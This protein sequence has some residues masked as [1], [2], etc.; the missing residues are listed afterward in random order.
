MTRGS[1]T[2]K[3]ETTT[4]TEDHQMPDPAGADTPDAARDRETDAARN[5]EADAIRD[6]ETGTARDQET[7]TTRSREAD[8]ARGR[9]TDAAQDRAADAARAPEGARELLPVATPARTRAVIRQLLRPHRGL[10]FGGF[11]VMVGATTVGLL[12]Q[13]L[14]GYLVDLVTE[15]RRST[16]S[17]CR[18]CSWCSS[19]SRRESPPR[20]GCR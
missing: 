11:V 3:A 17:P 16:R 14:L 13:P 4:T 10:L 15:H 1:G 20:S 19:R 9:E 12:T 7:G 2:E 18:R 8:A 6:Q 5:Q